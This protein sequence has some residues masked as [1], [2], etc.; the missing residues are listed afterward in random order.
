MQFL[1]IFGR[2]PIEIY[3]RRKAISS[4]YSY[5]QMA[6]VEWCHKFRQGKECIKDL[7]R[8]SIA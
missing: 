4:G 7:V 6:V 8:P 1:A 5:F 2:Q 3:T